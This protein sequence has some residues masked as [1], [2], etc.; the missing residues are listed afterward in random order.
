[1]KVKNYAPSKYSSHFEATLSKG[2]PLTEAAQIKRELI[3]R[4]VVLDDQAWNQVLDMV[5]DSQVVTHAAVQEALNSFIMANI[6]IETN[7]KEMLIDQSALDEKSL[8]DGES[9]WYNFFK[10]S[11]QPTKG[12][13]VDSS[14]S[15]NSKDE[16]TMAIMRTIHRQSS[17]NAI[18]RSTCMKNNDE[19]PVIIEKAERNKKVSDRLQGFLRSRQSA[20]VNYDEEKGDDDLRLNKTERMSSRLQKRSSSVGECL[21]LFG[22]SSSVG[23]DLNLLSNSNPQ[24]TQSSIGIIDERSIF[25]HQSSNSRPLEDESNGSKSH[26]LRR[27]DSEDTELPLQAIA[28]A[29]ELTGT[30]DTGSWVKMKKRMSNASRMSDMTDQTRYDC[31]ADDLSTGPLNTNFYDGKVDDVISID[32]LN[33]ENSQEAKFSTGRSK[34]QKR[35]SNESKQSDVTDT[36]VSCDF[37][38]DDSTKD[39]IQDDDQIVLLDFPKSENLEETNG[40]PRASDS[41]QKSNDSEFYDEGW[42]LRGNSCDDDDDT[43]SYSSLERKADEEQLKK[44]FSEKMCE[45]SIDGEHE[46][47]SFSQPA[48]YRNN[49]DGSFTSSMYSRLSRSKSLKKEEEEESKCDRSSVFSNASAET[50]VKKMHVQGEG[51]LNES[52]LDGILA[53]AIRRRVLAASMTKEK[54]C[55]SNVSSTP[56]MKRISDNLNLSQHG[57]KSFQKMKKTIPSRSELSMSLSVSQRQSRRSSDTGTKKKPPDSEAFR[58]KSAGEF[59]KKKNTD[60]IQAKISEGRASFNLY[61]A[62]SKFVKNR[63]ETKTFNMQR[64]EHRRALGGSKYVKNKDETKIFNMHRSEHRR[65]PGDASIM[66]KLALLSDPQMKL[67]RESSHNR[68]NLMALASVEIC[69][70]TGAEIHTNDGPVYANPREM[71]RANECRLKSTLFSKNSSSEQSTNLSKSEAPSRY[72]DLRKSQNISSSTLFSVKY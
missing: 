70:E 19:S 53:K 8:N 49:I 40:T 29:Q 43:E 65:A 37:N 7:E 13:R 20:L 3:R 44:L 22:K 21:N 2:S 27:A 60:I 61:Q 59:L 72:F 64:S 26:E 25:S 18:I 23:V 71:M 41:S 54:D 16:R 55:S 35:L 46:N 28:E 66:K 30:S 57:R 33:F 11:K 45:D 1:M 47:D 17:G 39:L 67:N 4:K 9:G 36:N 10:K 38:D 52:K 6:D 5:K 58:R 32:C 62:K 63:D 15:N 24:S 14:T 31:N 12:N 69:S 56:K 42:R 48:E 34:M 50:E 68:I 51:F